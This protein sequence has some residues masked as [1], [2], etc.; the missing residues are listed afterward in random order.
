MS[1]TVALCHLT[2]EPIDEAS[3]REAVA[4]PECGAVTVFAGV[5]RNRSRGREV[6]YLEYEA[7]EPMALKQMRRIAE[8]AA[9]RWGAR[10]AMVH[11]LGRMDVGETSVVIAVATPHR[12][13]AFEACRWC[14]DTLKEQVPIWKK[15]VCPDGTYWIE[16]EEAVR[17]QEEGK[18]MPC[19]ERSSTC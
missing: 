4:S 16:G 12:Q 17:A 9:R 6:R 19:E 2:R 10:V 14:I 18:E 7:Y 3:V 15:E 5:V 8:E 13:Q 1:G 11:R